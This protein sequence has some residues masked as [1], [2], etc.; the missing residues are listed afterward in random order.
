MSLFLCSYFQWKTWF[1]VTNVNSITPTPLLK[2]SSGHLLLPIAAS[3][4]T[5]QQLIS[6]STQICIWSSY[7]CSDW[8][9]GGWIAGY[10]G[11]KSG[12]TK[13]L[14]LPSVCWVI[15][16]VGWVG[17]MFLTGSHGGIKNPRTAW[18]QSDLQTVECCINTVG[19][20]VMWKEWLHSH[21]SKGQEC[22]MGTHDALGAQTLCSQDICSASKCCLWPQ[23]ILVQ[24]RL[25]E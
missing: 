18:L 4:P 17:N 24:M 20:N 5:I 23:S 11:S 12:L 19:I 16:K 13:Y 22:H 21:N 6:E 3:Q 15:Y 7:S 9:P 8:D 10:L 14:T 1:T 25:Q 2:L